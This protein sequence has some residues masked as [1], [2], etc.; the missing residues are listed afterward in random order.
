MGKVCNVDR[1]TETRPEIGVPKNKCR[2]ISFLVDFTWSGDFYKVSVHVTVVKG[3]FLNFR[4]PSPLGL[5]PPPKT[6]IWPLRGENVVVGYGCF[7][8]DL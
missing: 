7:G 2:N 6:V 1:L 5:G 8:T 4:Q 3:R